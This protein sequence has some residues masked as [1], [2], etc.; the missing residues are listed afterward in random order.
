[1]QDKFL[2]VFGH[3]AIDVTMKV[4]SIPTHGSVSIRKYEE[5]FGGT[6][7]NMAMVASRLRVPFDLFTA[8][9]SRT[10][11]PY[12]D[13]LSGIG[14]D[15]S[16]LVVE[17][18]D[19]GPIGYA[20][21]TGEEQVYYFYQGPMDKPLA[22]RIDFDPSSYSYIHLGTGLP[23]DYLYYLDG[24]KHSRIVFDP[25]QEIAYR[26]DRE[27][28]EPLL[29]NSYLTIMNKAEEEVAVGML[30]TDREDLRGRCRN[31]IITRGSAGA[32][33]YSGGESTDLASLKIENPHDTIGAGDAYRAGFYFG[34][35]QKLD[36]LD[37]AVMG[38]VIASEAIRKPFTEFNLSAS[39]A[40]ALYEEKRSKVLN[41]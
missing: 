32:T 15:T 33:Y 5:N 1:M 13:F 30:G 27:K 29:E 3:V 28:L 14:T 19:S 25:G 39:R 31:L 11:G 37:S 4:D 23:S 38:A 40:M 41:R 20:V 7:G 8:V 9:S 34:L 2:A 35:T 24:M 21:T 12:I 22:G 17:S 6:A 10:H 36:L 16:H 26:Y 18:S